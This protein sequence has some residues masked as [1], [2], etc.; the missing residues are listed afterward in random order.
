MARKFKNLLDR[1]IEMKAKPKKLKGNRVPKGS[2]ASK[3]KVYIVLGFGPDDTT[4]I[5]KVHSCPM[6]AGMHSQGLNYKASVGTYYSFIEKS[7]E[8]TRRK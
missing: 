5:I 4:H 1:L 3:Q 8:G 7:V 6:I 2:K